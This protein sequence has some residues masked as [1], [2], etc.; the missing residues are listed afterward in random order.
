MTT[1]NTAAH[2]FSMFNLEVFIERTQY[3]YPQ[4]FA[5]KK[6]EAGTVQLLVLNHQSLLLRLKVDL[7][8][9]V[10]IGRSLM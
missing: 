4:W 7:L 5:M 8:P 3:N 6:E 2:Y 9:S 10:Q 1:A